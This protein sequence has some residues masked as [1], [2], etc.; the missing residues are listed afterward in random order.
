MSEQFKPQNQILLVLGLLFLLQSF[1]FAA[2]SMPSDS[3]KNKDLQRQRL[4]DYRG[5][6][7]PVQFADLPVFNGRTKFVNGS[8]EPDKNGVSTCEMQYT[9]QEEPQTVVN[10]Y[11]DAFASRQLEN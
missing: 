7:E 8:Y 1:T 3:Q 6:K 2:Y 5:L 4:K 10:F 9:A 11:K